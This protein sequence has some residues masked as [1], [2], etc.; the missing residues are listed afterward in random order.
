MTEATSLATLEANV[1]ALTTELA[2]QIAIGNTRA[3][4]LVTLTTTNE[5]LRAQVAVLAGV[6]PPPPPALANNGGAMNLDFLG[7]LRDQSD[8]AREPSA[9]D[10]HRQV[11]DK[12]MKVAK[13][14]PLLPGQWTPASSKLFLQ[15]ICYVR[16]IAEDTTNTAVGFIVSGLRSHFS[17]TGQLLSDLCDLIIGLGPQ[18]RDYVLL[19]KTPKEMMELLQP[20]LDI[21][22]SKIG[23]LT[24]RISE[25]AS[26]GARGDRKD[27]GGKNKGGKNNRGGGNQ[28][29]GDFSGGRGNRGGRGGQAE[30]EESTPEPEARAKRAKRG[31]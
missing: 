31:R 14:T 15:P 25:R 20:Q 16:I 29:G 23:F 3:T 2:A 13:L 22:A 6:P 21:M 4:Q 1:K 17:T 30:Q 24:H 18:V 11:A 7:V 10:T 19:A 27:K 9:T 28:G 12:I 8:A 5:Q 26:P